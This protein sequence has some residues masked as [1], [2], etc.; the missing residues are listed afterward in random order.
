MKTEING[1]WVGYLKRFKL[2]TAKA[3]IY[4]LRAA[5][6]IFGILLGISVILYLLPVKPIVQFIP[7]MS[8]ILISMGFYIKIHY[9]MFWERVLEESKGFFADLI[10]WIYYIVIC[11]LS[12]MPAC[13]GL[14]N[15]FNE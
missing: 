14:N 2:P 11:I 1:D 9:K 12:V 8:G 15:V 10:M 3:F 6:I 5:G 13:W 7:L 4:P